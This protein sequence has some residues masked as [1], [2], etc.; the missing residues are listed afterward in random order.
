M[1]SKPWENK[2]LNNKN[3]SI[4]HGAWALRPDSLRILQSQVVLNKNANQFAC[5]HFQKEANSV[6]RK[7]LLLAS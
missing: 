1:I 7:H 4:S 6:Q 2:L 5:S 3:L